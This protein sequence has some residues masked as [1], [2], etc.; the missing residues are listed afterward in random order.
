[1]SDSRRCLDAIADAVASWP[2]ESAFSLPPLLE[3]TNHHINKASGIIAL[4]QKIGRS[5]QS[6]YA[7]GDGENDLPLFQVATA[8]FAP[9]TA[10]EPIKAAASHIIDAS[11]DGL[12]GPILQFI[13]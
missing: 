8:S 5:G 13:G 2:V 4:L 3:I 12:L 7:V 6:F 11:R 1:M 10:P 9:S